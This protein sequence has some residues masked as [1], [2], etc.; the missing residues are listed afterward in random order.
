MFFGMRALIVLDVEIDEGKRP[1]TGFARLEW[2]AGSVAR[3][4]GFQRRVKR[5]HSTTV[6]HPAAVD[7]LPSLPLITV[8]FEATLAQA[9]QR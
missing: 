1:G 9:V 3:F 6:H 8:E 2:V 4:V 7:Q 5:L